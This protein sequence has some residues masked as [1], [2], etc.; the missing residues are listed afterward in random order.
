MKSREKARSSELCIICSSNVE[1]TPYIQLYASQLDNFDIVYW[2]RFKLPGKLQNANNSYAFHYHLQNNYSKTKA[3]LGYAGYA[4]FVTK[5]LSKNK[6]KGLIILQAQTGVLISRLLKNKY[7]NRYIFD[8]RDYSYEYNKFYYRIESSLVKSS[9]ANIISSIGFISFLPRAEYQLVHNLPAIVPS[10][11]SIVKNRDV[12]VISY[13]GSINYFEQCQKLINEFAEDDRFII[14]FIGLGSDN[15]KEYI[16]KPIPSNI[17]F[18]GTYQ[19]EDIESLYNSSDVIANVYGNNNP[20]LDYAIS[21]KLY[22]CAMFRK[23]ILVSPGTAM[24]EV[25]KQLGIG[26]AMDFLSVGSKEGLLQFL[27]EFSESAV[28][29]KCDEFLQTC[30]TDNNSVN[31]TIKSFI[32]SIRSG[33]F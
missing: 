6:Y 7:K 33:G 20:L 19:S 17:R 31:K 11:S 23:P 14:N 1:L 9:Y 10:S 5:H 24:E 32:S 15:L 2:D 25:S 22:L 28:A 8:I 27:K 4:R 12:T 26:Y 29:Q 16:S 30:R 18:R 13:I 21:N 3:L